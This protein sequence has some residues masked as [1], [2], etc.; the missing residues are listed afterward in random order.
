MAML[1]YCCMGIFGALRNADAADR[2]EVAA[3]DADAR[4]RLAQAE[5]Y[6]SDAQWTEAIDLL[7][8]LVDRHGNSL[9]AH[10]RGYGYIPLR[11]HVHNILSQLP[12][13][14]LRVYRSKFDKRAAQMYDLA[15][16]ARDQE[17]LERIVENYFCSS[18]GDQALLA[19]GEML[20]QRGQ[21]HSAGRTWRRLIPAAELAR[22]EI[23]AAT[24]TYSIASD[25]T[26]F[27]VYPD[28][29]VAIADVFV[30]LI[31]LDCLKGRPLDAR[32]KLSYFKRNYPDAIGWFAG[33]NTNLATALSEFIENAEMSPLLAMKS[34]SD[35]CNADFASIGRS[36]GHDLEI[37]EINWVVNLGDAS[38]SKDGTRD[39]M[40]A[41]S[42]SSRR[43]MT[44]PRYHPIC[45]DVAGRQ[46]ILVNDGISIL[47]FD[48]KTGKPAWANRDNDG[49][50]YR[51]HTSD[52]FAGINA[53]PGFS[54]HTLTVHGTN[55]YARLGPTGNTYNDRIQSSVDSGHLVCLNLLAEGRLMWEFPQPADRFAFN[56]EKW[57][58]AGPPT[59]DGQQVHVALTKHGTRTANYVTCLDAAAGRQLWTA[60]VCALTVPSS[61]SRASQAENGVVRHEQTLYYNTNHGAIAALDASD[62]RLCW[63]T[64]YR[65]AGLDSPTGEIPLSGHL[66]NLCIF[67]EGML[68]VAPSDAGLVFALDAGTGFPIWQSSHQLSGVRDLMGVYEN[69]LI[70]SGDR[71]YAIDRS[72][73]QLAWMW[74]PGPEKTGHGRGIIA[75][76]KFY[77]PSGAHEIRVFDA[78]N[79]IQFEAPFY[80]GQGRGT[81]GDLF[82]FDGQLLV[83]ERERLV[84]YSRRAG[85]PATN[86]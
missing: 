57:M 50:I 10:P 67:H 39:P 63:L 5:A 83:A 21:F 51:H 45:A 61:S 84:A 18:V 35:R 48:R 4:R 64:T 79:G 38:F 77:W 28:P 25:S 42:A 29:D 17:L 70:A 12:T 14:A 75:N 13:D 66:S 3:L 73:G 49:R 69:L 2:L 37:G 54:Q 34:S 26:G 59:C 65:R 86:K 32:K 56:E 11:E 20:V 47:A 16:P 24:Q 1:F 82:L 62:G 53:S 71:L 23:E 9:A 31:W 78:Q 36:V 6:A 33:K 52:S 7:Q 80:L 74:P 27:A 22:I 41:V 55:A 58:I 81:T 15:L 40:A 46:L 60:F 19:L 85:N 30:R 43:R 76:G 68:I 72:Q 44:H 8:E